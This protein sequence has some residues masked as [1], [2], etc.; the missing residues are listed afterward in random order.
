M[1]V[2]ANELDNPKTQ[3]PKAIFIASFLC[4]VVLGV[5]AIAV[6][7]ILPYNQIQLDSGVMQ[8]FKLGFEHYKL[9]WLTNIIAVLV[10]VG[11]AAS[12]IA[13]I[14][15]P[16]KSLLYTTKDNELPKFMAVVNKDGVQIN[17]LLLQGT[18]VTL[19]CSLYFFMDNVNVAFFLL[20]SLN[21]TLYLVMYV[22]MYLAGMKLR[23][24]QPDLQRP[25]KVPGGKNGMF[26]F[27]GVG[28]IAVVFA[29]ILCFIP[30]TELPISSPTFYTVFLIVGTTVFILIPV[31]VS[32]YMKNHNSK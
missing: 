29:L 32:K 7:V 22:L 20:S 17:I 2:H 21:A 30:P 4:F 26:I 19:L 31:F 12:V 8:A 5:G 27:G 16:S 23:K 10:V 11:C 14:S 15:G 9:E 28:F 25:F 13:W 1:A 3:Y 18:I 24:T 6:S